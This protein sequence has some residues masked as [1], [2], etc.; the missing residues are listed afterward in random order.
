[1]SLFTHRPSP[2]A[3]AADFGY[4][5]Q[6]TQQKN[7]R[8]TIVG[9]PYWMAPEL[10][11]GQEY[12]TKVDIWSLGIMIMEMAE[13]E[14]P[15]MEFPPLRV[16]ACASFYYFAVAS[17]CLLGVHLAH[18]PL[19]HHPGPVLDHNE[20]YPRPQGALEVVAALPE[21]RV[22]HPREGPKREARRERAVEGTPPYPLSVHSHLI[23]AASGADHSSP[24]LSGLLA[25]SVHEDVDRRQ[26]A[27][28][29]DRGREEGRGQEQRA[30]GVE[31]GGRNQAS[32]TW[33]AAPYVSVQKVARGSGVDNDSS[34]GGRRRWRQGGGQ[35]VDTS[36][37]SLEWPTERLRP[38]G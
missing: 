29:G 38:V 14:P 1:M 36:D 19:H 13:G 22:P 4:A 17:V 9:T 28:A 26:R 7:K 18:Q 15:Y 33:L 21:L 10:I 12:D 16:L 31:G 5:A 32:T 2:F 30:V 23:K 6:L 35:I 24:S 11:R 34:T 27:R 8:Q 37:H 20:G 3:R 25:A